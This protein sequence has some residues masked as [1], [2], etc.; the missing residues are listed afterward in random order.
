MSARFRVNARTSSPER[1]TWSA[2]AVEL[3]LHRRRA[4]AGESVVEVV[5]GLR[6][7]RLDRAQHCEAEPGQP[8]RALADRGGGHR[9]DL[10]REHDRPPDLSGG[11][12]RGFRDRLHHHARERA[13]AQLAEDEP[14]EEP[15]LRPRSRARRALRSRRAARPAS[16]A[17]RCPR[18]STRLRPPRGAR[19]WAAAPPAS[20][21][22]EAPPSRRRSSPAA[23][24][25]RGRRPRSAPP[26][27]TPAP[28]AA[29]SRD[30]F[31]SRDDVAATSADASAISFRSTAPSCRTAHVA[32]PPRARESS[33]AASE[34]V[35]VIERH[36]DGHDPHVHDDAAAAKRDQIDVVT[37]SRSSSATTRNARTSCPAR[38]NGTAPTL[39]IVASLWSRAFAAIQRATRSCA[40]FR[41][42]VFACASVKYTAVFEAAPVVSAPKTGLHASPVAVSAERSASNSGQSVDRGSRRP[43]PPSPP[44]SRRS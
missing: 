8:F 16:R 41:N 18:S 31:A 14:D 17:R 6:E 37:S 9:P 4:D 5:A 42:A 29:A 33:L 30:T 38:G 13:L 21:A 12:V 35:S 40:S 2:R 20:G 1:C 23:G 36:A 11:K 7:H 44:G 28:S 32:Q 34:R 24:R 25:P 22:R 3:P 19:S 43:A 39:W 27:A 15:L 10:A 26:P